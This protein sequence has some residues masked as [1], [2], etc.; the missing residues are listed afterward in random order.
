MLLHDGVE[1]IT[2]VAAYPNAY[3]GTVGCTEW[4]E[5]SAVPVPEKKV[6]EGL[7]FNQFV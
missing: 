4:T 5:F 7:L 6:T 3:Y 1:V 2:S